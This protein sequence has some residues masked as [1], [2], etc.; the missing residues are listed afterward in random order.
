MTPFHRKIKDIQLA[1]FLSIA[2]AFL[3]VVGKAVGL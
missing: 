3:Y 1:A 2:I